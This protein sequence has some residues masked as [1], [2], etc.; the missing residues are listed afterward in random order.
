[1]LEDW[2]RSAWIL[3]RRHHYLSDSKSGCS[4]NRETRTL[5][6]GDPVAVSAR[7]CFPL[8]VVA[9]L[10]AASELLGLEYSPVVDLEYSPVVDSALVG[11]DLM[12]KQLH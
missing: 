10:A 9:R 12:A 1:V 8:I 3:I 7:P 2:R 4:K 11:P 5:R 6:L